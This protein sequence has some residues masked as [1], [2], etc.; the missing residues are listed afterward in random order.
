M[1]CP[2]Q[3][4]QFRDWWISLPLPFELSKQIPTAF[5]SVSK[6]FKEVQEKKGGTKV[7]L[8]LRP[9]GKTQQNAYHLYPIKKKYISGISGF[10]KKKKMGANFCIMAETIKQHSKTKDPEVQN[11]C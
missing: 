4:D 1:S 5:L 7:F 2:N 8:S 6:S 3:H 10:V 9:E 11:G